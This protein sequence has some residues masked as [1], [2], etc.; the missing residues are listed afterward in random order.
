MVKVLIVKLRAKF[1][2]VFIFSSA[3][4]ECLTVWH[5]LKVAVIRK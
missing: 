4:N 3:C 2:C 5:S 1:Y